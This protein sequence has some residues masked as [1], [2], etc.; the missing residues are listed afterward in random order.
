MGNGSGNR[1]P[2]LPPIR[3]VD[4]GK[5]SDKTMLTAMRLCTRAHV[6]V[7]ASRGMSEMAGTEELKN[8]TMESLIL[9]QD[10]R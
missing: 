10:E 6:T 3:V 4:E 2:K 8:T 9:A 7:T 1:E 5:A